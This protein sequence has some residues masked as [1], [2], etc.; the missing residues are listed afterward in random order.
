MP[1]E[2]GIWRLGEKPER[3]NFSPMDAEKR[4]EVRTPSTRTCPSWCR[5]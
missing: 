2:V 3:I 5:G 1:I 4:L